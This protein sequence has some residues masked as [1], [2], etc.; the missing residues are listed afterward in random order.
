MS[1]DPSCRFVIRDPVTRQNLSPAFIC[2]SSG[3]AEATAQTL[4]NC[5]QRDVELVAV[6]SSGFNLP[7]VQGNTGPTNM[8]YVPSTFVHGTGCPSAGVSKVVTY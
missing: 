5:L 3:D 6:S 1:S 7:S 8:S 4:A 2:S